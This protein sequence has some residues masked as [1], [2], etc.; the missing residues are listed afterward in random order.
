MIGTINHAQERTKD[1]SMKDGYMCPK[2]YLKINEEQT[3]PRL[4]IFPIQSL[5]F[6][7]YSVLTINYSWYLLANYRLRICVPVKDSTASGDFVILG[8]QA[9]HLLGATIQQLV[10][11]QITEN[12]FMPYKIQALINETISFTVRCCA[13]PI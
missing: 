1:W 2:C 12:Q 10:H 11:A 8:K 9:E 7:L 3:V 13:Y 4:Y 6:Q 5:I